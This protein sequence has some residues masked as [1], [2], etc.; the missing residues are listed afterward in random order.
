MKNKHVIEPVKLYILNVLKINIYNKIMNDPII[1]DYLNITNDYKEKYGEKIILL[2]QV[3]AFFEI[4]GLKD[5]DG[6]IGGSQ[7]LDI[8]SICQLNFS[9]KKSSYQNKQVIMAGFRDFSLDKFIPKMIDSGYTAV[10]YVQEKKNTGIIRKLEGI[11][12]PGTYLSNENTK[13]N[14]ITNNIMCVWIDKIKQNFEERLIYGISIINIFTGKSYIFEHEVQYLLNPTTFDELERAV[15]VFSPSEVIFISPFEN[16]V[17]KTIQN[18]IGINN[19]SIHNININDKNEKIENCTKQTYINQILSKFFNEECKNQC[20]EF[21]LYTIACQSF[22]YLLDFVQEHN[23][24]LVKKIA[25]PIFN[26]SST[27]TVL[28]NHT[29]KQLNIIDDNQYHGSLS[30]VLNFLNKC[31]YSGG[32][33]LFKHQLTNPCFDENWLNNE[34]RKID[35]FDKN[36]VDYLRIVLSSLPD[37][38]K[39]LRQML[40][41]KIYPFHIWQLYNSLNVIQTIF[42]NIEN[43]EIYDYL[44]NNKNIEEEINKIKDFID[45]HFIIEDCKK[46]QTLQTFECNF[47]KEGVS[48]ELDNL[49]NEQ[50][51]NE[52]MFDGIHALFNNFMRTSQKDA[53]TEF[54]KKH[55]TE[56]SG[57]SLQLT[58]K[59]ASTLKT[60]LSKQKVQEVQIINKSFLLSE[61]KISSA[62]TSAD[63][64]NF[65]LLTYITKNRI[66]LQDQ[67]NTTICIIFNE[68]LE[69]IEENWLNKIEDLC[70][71]SAKTDVLVTKVH[72]A[73]KYNYC[74]PEIDQYSEKSFVK[75]KNIKHCLIEHLQ[76]SETYVTNDI[77]LGCNDQNGILL[78]GT[79]AVGK[80]SLIRALGIAVILAQAGMYVPCSS[81]LYKPYTAIYSRILGN[82]NLFKGLSTFAV[83][84]SELRVIL[85]MADP[86]SLILGDEVC[87]GTETESALSIFVTSLMSIYKNNS[88]FIFA[89][90]FHEILNYDEIKQLESLK[91]YH[92]HVN[93]DRENDCLVYDRKLK[94][95][96]GT[97]MYGLEV[98]K[99]LYLE[100]DFLD[101]AYELRNKYF[102]ENRGELSNKKS[103]Y[104]AKKIKSLCEMCNISISTE[105][106]HLFPQKDAL[107]NGYIDN[108]HKN[109]PGNLAALCEECHLKIHKE[110]KQIKKKKT[111][112][113]IKLIEM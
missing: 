81:F 108:F 90:H 36:K 93:F 35:I 49:I 99:S 26:N 83:E 58:K 22:C 45:N 107:P 70:C 23:N 69:K 54:I 74:K 84:I 110:N 25:L 66:K 15:S 77:H 44:T 75:A 18:F 94:L 47:I 40:I 64:I 2:M 12:S 91:I 103:I 57:V 89:T 7:I 61:I 60:I 37:M 80:T 17:V 63:E 88:S 71:F 53:D 92:M 97:R 28:A 59:R 13:P 104:N 4:Y 33:R 31:T 95:G 56:K 27:R 79:N 85:R 30:S 6:I 87:S 67:I 43:D 11:Y 29:L 21:N 5:I 38:E 78:Y 109:S 105:T 72:I 65:P 42:E 14:N 82:D 106:H 34:Y 86:R 39:I 24:G 73:N 112:K 8:C 51:E 68:L 1:K 101:K 46:I 62:S 9:E 113:G 111:T 55:Q 32:K 100:N 3:G 41:R 48:Q 50:K 98:C 76:T 19:I 102:P 20:Q 16:N 52:E 10:V 96:A